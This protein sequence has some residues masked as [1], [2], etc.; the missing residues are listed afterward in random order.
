MLCSRVQWIWLF[1]SSVY[2]RQYCVFLRQYCVNLRQSCV[3]R[4]QYSV[5]LRQYCVFLLQYCVNLHQ[6]YVKLCQN[7]VFLC[8]YSVGIF[9]QSVGARNRVGIGLLYWPTIACICKRL[10]SPGF[11]SKESIFPGW[12]S[13]S[14]LHK[15]STNMG[16]GYIGWGNWFLEIYS[17]APWKV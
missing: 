14:G 10:W 11:D 13:I 1:L 6:Y 4:R 2:L 12:E 7:C 15:R 9:K 3:F 5:Q 17:W 8:K 16:S